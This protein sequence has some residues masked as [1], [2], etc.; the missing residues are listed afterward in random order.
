M[1]SFKINICILVQFL[2]QLTPIIAQ[3]NF[4]LSFSGR[5]NGAWVQLGGNEMITQLGA[6]FTMEI[7]FKYFINGYTPIISH[8]Q[9]GYHL[10][11]VQDFNLQIYQDGRLS[12][13]MGNGLNTD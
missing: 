12:F 6:T 13:F 4:A 1:R 10:N 11:R 5:A 3:T 7:W 8:F 2:F 9:E